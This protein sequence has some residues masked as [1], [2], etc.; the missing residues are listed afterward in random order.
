MVTTQDIAIFKK[1]TAAILKMQVG[2]QWGLE[3]MP[4]LF[5]QIHKTPR[6]PK[7]NSFHFLQKG[8]ATV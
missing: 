7:M 5:F 6:F 4:T 2:G 8:A 1:K 3:K